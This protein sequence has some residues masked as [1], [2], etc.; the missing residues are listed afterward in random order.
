GTRKSWRFN[1]AFW[2]LVFLILLTRDLWGLDLI[3]RRTATETALLI[4]GR[5]LTL[6]SFTVVLM[7]IVQFLLALF[8]RGLRWIVITA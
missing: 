4:L 3:A 5:F 1:G 8:P 7:L 2:L 6:A